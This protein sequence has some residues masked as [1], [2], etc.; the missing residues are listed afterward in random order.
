MTNSELRGNATAIESE[1]QRLRALRDTLDSLGDAVRDL[2]IDR[3]EGPAR[4]AFDQFRQRY[5]KRLY[6][7]AELHDDAATHLDRY[8]R[9]LV[10]LR[11]RMAGA[12]V[13]PGVAA[14]DLAR[15]QGQLQTE[16]HTAAVAIRTVAA[17]LDALPP[18]LPEPPERVPEPAANVPPAVLTSGPADRSGG[19]D[20]R[21]VYGD[22]ASFQ[23][24][25][26]E[27][28]AQIATGKTVV[29]GP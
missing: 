27:L 1:V 25:I 8:Y 12:G 11:G 28:R 18:L 13:V 7:V 15:W 2:A 29:V 5:W 21:T 22:P 10:D 16:A 26:D 3:W 9:T 14:D 19:L 20:I 17:A 23:R 24:D 4:E 6:E